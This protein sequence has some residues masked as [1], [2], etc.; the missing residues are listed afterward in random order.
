MISRIHRSR[1]SIL[2]LIMLLT[3]LV[4][5]FPLISPTSAATQVAATSEANLRSGP[6]TSY[7]IVGKV[8]KGE[9]LSVLGTS[10]GWY[11]IS[12]SNGSKGWIAGW[13]V[14]QVKTTVPATTKTAAVTSTKVTVTG[15]T[16]NVR[17]GPGTNYAK[18]VVAKK[19]QQF[20]VIRLAN[21]WYNISL[22]SG[23]T[24]W[25]ISSLVQVV[26]A[27]P[28][29]SGT[30]ITLEKVAVTGTTLNLRKGP[31]ANYATI[32]Q[33]KKGQQYYV[34]RRQTGW[35]NL[36]ISSTKNGWVSDKYVKTI[37][38]ASGGT[39]TSAPASNTST[40]PTNFAKKIIITG[41]VVNIRT[42]PATTYSVTSQVKRYDEFGFIQEKNG[43]YRVALSAAKTGWITK[44][45]ASLV[46][47][48]YSTGEVIS[49]NTDVYSADQV[50]IIIKGSAPINFRKTVLTNPNRTVI[51]LIGFNPGK[52]AGSKTLAVNNMLQSYYLSQYTVLPRVA[53]LTINQTKSCYF[54][55]SLSGDKKTLTL[56]YRDGGILAGRKIVV[57]AGHGDFDPGAI[58]QTGLK[59]KNV[60][61]DIATD[62]AEDLRAL[63]ADVTM[64]RSDDTFVG[65]YDR[66]G[67]ANNLGADLFISVHSNSSTSSSANGTSTYYYAP[68]SRTDLAAQAKQRLYLAQ[69]VQTELVKA[70]GRKNL[71][72]LTNQ[73]AVLSTT[74]MPS[75]LV[76]TAFI[77]NPTEE[78]LLGDPTT[79]GK[80]AQGICN[81]VV[82][83][84]DYYK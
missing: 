9:K 7:K 74:K 72:V 81:G 43:W 14:S 44:T 33:V 11:N 1:F 38:T 68:A 28:S 48:S 29:R 51:D 25:I 31:G 69:V 41:S 76:E 22:G 20:Q 19:G 73:L 32:G 62:L 17:S 57:D 35:C 42:G 59:E 10:K 82:D 64:T 55:T 24:G 16:V 52:A 40:V 8:A 18:V 67:I 83:Y 66:S 79:Q 4:T 71:G 36:L 27:T 53:R 3:F 80:F 30:S 56:T 61:L 47:S 65:L 13:L 77:S 21:G 26:Q 15:T 75:I 70:V 2:A 37:K 78:K 49:V 34:I 60:N 50:S 39:T 12:K 5:M 46:P 23:K 54:S 58:G 84:F 63:G 6:S 45:L